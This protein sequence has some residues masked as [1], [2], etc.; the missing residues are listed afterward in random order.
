MLVSWECEELSFPE[1]MGSWGRTHS[2]WGSKGGNLAPEIYSTLD[3]NLI[4]DLCGRVESGGSSSLDPLPETWKT[5]QVG[6]PD[7]TCENT[8]RGS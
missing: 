6:S 3:L 5:M 7:Q 4:P 2:V 1:L 8:A